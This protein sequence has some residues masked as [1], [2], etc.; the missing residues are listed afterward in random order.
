MSVVN[1]GEAT[2]ALW[3]SQERAHVCVWVVVVVSVGV[4]G[5]GVWVGDVFGV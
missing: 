1:A 5:G 4:S 3:P 2:G